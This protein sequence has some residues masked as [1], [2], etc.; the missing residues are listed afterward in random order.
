MVACAAEGEC[1][2]DRKVRE[3]LGG[4]LDRREVLVSCACC[5]E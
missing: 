5:D 4:T 2:K 3:C 1:G